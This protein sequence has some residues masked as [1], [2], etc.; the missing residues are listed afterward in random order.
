MI[1]AGAWILHCSQ[2]MIY[3]LKIYI[4]LAWWTDPVYVCQWTYWDLLVQLSQ[5]Q[6]CVGLWHGGPFMMELDLSFMVDPELSIVCYGGW[7]IFTFLNMLNGCPFSVFWINPSMKILLL[8]LGFCK[9]F[10]CKPD[11]KSVPIWQMLL[12]F[13]FASSQDWWMTNDNHCSVK[14]STVGLIQFLF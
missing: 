9:R 1:M 4:C 7:W 10:N 3:I 13:R 6:V 11:W 5:Y 12:Q 8:V 2:M 14:R